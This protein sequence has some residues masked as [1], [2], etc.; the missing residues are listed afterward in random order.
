MDD[1][2]SASTPNPFAAP[3][4]SS[5]TGP[6]V[7]PKSTIWPT[8]LGIIVIVFGVMGVLGG[9]LNLASTM[10][11]TSVMSDLM[12]DID[13]T[14]AATFQIM[15]SVSTSMIGLALFAILMAG[16][17][18]SL[19]IGILRKRPWAPRMAGTWSLAKMLVVFA[20]SLFG[21]RMQQ[22]QFE[23]MAG[24]NS[25]PAPFDV[26]EFAAIISYVGMAFALIW[27]WALPV[28][29]LLWFRREVIRAEVAG[30]SKKAPGDKDVAAEAAA[31][32]ESG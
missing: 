31:V 13:A 22:A 26:Q 29:L 24:Q 20:Q 21:I 2:N 1:P 28:F 16:W 4:L 27:G 10:F 23:V 3:S 12:S 15:E 32:D 5:E 30:W 14:S 7:V 17:L 25:G 11:M 6:V 9:C 18:V 8:S 19:G